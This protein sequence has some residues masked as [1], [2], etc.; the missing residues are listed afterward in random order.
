MFLYLNIGH[1]WPLTL[2]HRSI[3]A[4]PVFPNILNPQKKEAFPRGCN[5]LFTIR[6][7]QI[8]K[9]LKRN[10]PEKERPFR[11][12]MCERFFIDSSVAGR[13]GVTSTTILILK[14]TP[15]LFMMN[16]ATCLPTKW[17]RQTLH[18]GLI[19]DLTGLMVWTARH[20]DIIT[21]IRKQ[22]KS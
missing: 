8:K 15:V 7:R 16:Y 12:P 17:Q 3:S 22:K 18:N 19:Q 1:K 5:L 6:P 20:R 11:K 4:K 21:S 13:I 10:L 14:K 2:W 9:P